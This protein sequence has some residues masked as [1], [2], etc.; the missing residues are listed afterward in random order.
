MGE[1]QRGV[2]G[3]LLVVMNEALRLRGL[4]R[5]KVV[6]PTIATQRDL[7]DDESDATPASNDC[8]RNVPFQM[9][10]LS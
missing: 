2:R 8:L 1:N 9:T 5:P 6:R 3:G 4:I 7:C 10:K